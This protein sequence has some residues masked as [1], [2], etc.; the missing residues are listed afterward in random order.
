M[1]PKRNSA[2]TIADSHTWSGFR[3]AKRSIMLAGCRRKM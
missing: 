1:A 3:A 2:A